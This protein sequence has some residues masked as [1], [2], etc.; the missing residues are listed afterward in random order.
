MCFPPRM[1]FIKNE[2]CGV[3]AVVQL[4]KDLALSLQQLG[5]QVW[6]P[7]PCGELK[8]LV[9]RQLWHRSQLWF[10]SDPW[11]TNFYMPRMQPQK[12]F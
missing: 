7:A 2:F 3:P 6:P 9:L 10:R 12:G 8:D 5:F 11:P 1:N 4:V